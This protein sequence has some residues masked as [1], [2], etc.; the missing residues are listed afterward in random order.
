MIPGEYI[1]IIPVGLIIL[2]IILSTEAGK[3]RKKSIIQL[4]IIFIIFVGIYF[5]STL[6]TKIAQGDIDSVTDIL[7]QENEIK[8]LNYTGAIEDTK[9]FLSGNKKGTK[10]GVFSYSVTTMSGQKQNWTVTWESIGD[11]YTISN[12]QTN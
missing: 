2:A 10:V 12:I 11:T 6:S 8:E 4:L 5:A 9:K 3:N 7:T 1:V